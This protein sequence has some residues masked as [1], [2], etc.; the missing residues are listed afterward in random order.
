MSSS[1]REVN[2]AVGAE[3]KQSA[4]ALLAE[5]REA[6]DGARERYSI[7]KQ[8]RDEEAMG[9]ESRRIDALRVIIGELET[10]AAGDQEA[11]GVV[12][13][14]KRIVAISR[15]SGSV[16][17]SLEDDEEKVAAAAEAY[18]ATVR[19]LNERYRQLEGLAA[20]SRALV[21]RFGVAGAK[22]PTVTPPDGRDGVVAAV[23]LVAPLAF[24]GYFSARPS[25][26]ED[27]HGLRSRRTYE[28]VS[29]SE[30][31]RIITS[32]G[33][34]PWPALT[35]RQQAAVAAVDAEHARFATDPV[36]A[37]ERDIIAAVPPGV[38]VQSA[39]VHRR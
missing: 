19:C 33:L 29:G 9:E 37:A 2:A 24:A 5:K 20:E 12:A 14:E 10:E 23:R 36:L 8:T 16:A 17:A 11:D 21:D 39:G 31:Y 1:S 32:A 26:E 34:K 38:P 13:A 18:A 35:A 30:A 22:I 4:T 27:E 15:A 28:E 3:G 7:A 6:L 25:F